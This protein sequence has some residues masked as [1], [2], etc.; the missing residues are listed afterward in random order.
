MPKGDIPI[1]H[2]G[3]E[4]RRMDREVEK[5]AQRVAKRFEKRGEA[6]FERARGWKPQAWAIVV[7]RA[8]EIIGGS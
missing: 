7:A 6:A 1:R 3:A 8:K 5:I 2:G 4:G